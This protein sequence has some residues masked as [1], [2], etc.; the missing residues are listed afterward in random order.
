MS[1]VNPLIQKKA[2]SELTQHKSIGVDVTG[3]G[4]DAN[5]F[6]GLLVK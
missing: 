1:I 2:D 4:N 5:F 6:I 3:R